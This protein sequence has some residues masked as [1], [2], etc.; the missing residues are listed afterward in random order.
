MTNYRGEYVSAEELVALIL[1][2][3][4]REIETLL[5]Q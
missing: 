4:E 3:D 5:G 1:T 2:A